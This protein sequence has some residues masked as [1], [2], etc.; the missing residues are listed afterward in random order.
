[1]VWWRCCSREYNVAQTVDFGHI[2]YRI[3]EGG[4]GACDSLLYENKMSNRVVQTTAVHVGAT[5]YVHG[6]D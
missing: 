4:A 6:H 2:T 5:Q 3:E 1:M